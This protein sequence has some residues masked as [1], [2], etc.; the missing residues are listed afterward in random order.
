MKKARFE[1]IPEPSSQD[2]ERWW[3]KVGMGCFLGLPR[4]LLTAV[5]AEFWCVLIWGTFGESTLI[6]SHPFLPN[7]WILKHIFPS[8]QNRKN[9]S[10]PKELSFRNS[11]QPSS[12]YTPFDLLLTLAVHE[13]PDRTFNVTLSDNSFEISFKNSD[14]MGYKIKQQKWKRKWNIQSHVTSGIQGLACNKQEQEG[15]SNSVLPKWAN[16]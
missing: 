5:E 6:L 10:L 13:R 8:Y 7:I 15:M 16:L 9:S 4:G 12:I 14:G 1:C 11:C 2:F 3:F